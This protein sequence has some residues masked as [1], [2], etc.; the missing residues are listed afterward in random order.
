ML[1]KAPFLLIL[2]APLLNADRAAAQSFYEYL[3]PKRES[4]VKYS[5]K[6]RIPYRD[7]GFDE[8]AK[9][10][11]KKAAKRG[12]P[13]WVID[14]INIFPGSA[15]ALGRWIDEAF[16]EA[17]ASFTRCRGRLAEF[18]SGISPASLTGGVVIEPTIW[19]EPALSAYL[20]GGYYPATRSIRV[21]N[22]YYGK[23]GDYRHARLL[24]KWEMKNHFAVLAGIR[25]EPFAP[26]WPCNAR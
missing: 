14:E 15:D 3:G 7:N 13:S 18:A 2:I 26:D 11:W 9:H 16:D 19:Y 12:A 25:S 24:L 8:P 21:V 5:P 20:A 17:R 6:Y 10:R 22:V 4:G 1:K 23:T